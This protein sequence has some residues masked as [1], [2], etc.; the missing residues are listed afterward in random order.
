MADSGICDVFPNDAFDRSAEHDVYMQELS[1]LRHKLK[2]EMVAYCFT[3]KGADG[4]P[5]RHFRFD[6]RD[7]TPIGE[8]AGWR[9]EEIG[10]TG[11]VLIVND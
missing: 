5:D 9:Y 7:V 6:K 10:G 1:Y 11:K 3:I 2:I 8:V 4:A